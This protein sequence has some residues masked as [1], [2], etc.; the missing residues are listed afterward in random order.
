MKTES[1]G[2]PKTL[3]EAVRLALCIGPLNGVEHKMKAYVRDYL[4]QR[5]AVAMIRAKTEN[6]SKMIEELWQS[7]IREEK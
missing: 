2:T 5:F 6:E 3:F 1:I 4:A 7:I